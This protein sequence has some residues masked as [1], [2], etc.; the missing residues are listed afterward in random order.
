MWHF[1]VN[2]HIYD[3]LCYP[4]MAQSQYLMAI[5]SKRGLSTLCHS[6]QVCFLAEGAK[7]RF[8][9]LA[10]YFSSEVGAV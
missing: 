9:V 8:L 2:L 4:A 3:S 5:G 7:K 1:L 6:F 10:D